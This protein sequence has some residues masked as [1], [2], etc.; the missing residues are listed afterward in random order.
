MGDMDYGPSKFMPH[1]STPS[2]DVSDFTANESYSPYGFNMILGV[3]GI[4]LMFGGLI[5]YLSTSN[6]QNLWIL[7]IGILL[8]LL[9]RNVRNGVRWM[10]GI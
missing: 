5:A 9:D 6:S 3:V 10:L 7:G 1:N 8:A 4:F 2:E